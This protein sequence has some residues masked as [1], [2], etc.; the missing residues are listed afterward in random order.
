MANI[1]HTKHINEVNVKN[2]YNESTCRSLNCD[3]H[4]QRLLR[5]SFNRI[6]ALCSRNYTSEPSKRWR[7]S[8]NMKPMYHLLPILLVLVSFG[9]LVVYGNL[10]KEDIDH[11][12]SKKATEDPP[13][14]PAKA[15]TREKRDILIMTMGSDTRQRCYGGP[16][17]PGYCDQPCVCH[18]WVHRCGF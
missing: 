11:V 2:E 14:S 10:E 13:G 9:N 16:C 6:Y 7:K 8:K 3:S 4:L 15:S 18:D 17:N 1:S 5:L 12:L